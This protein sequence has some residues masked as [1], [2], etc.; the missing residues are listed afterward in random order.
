MRELEAGGDLV[1]TSGRSAN[2]SPAELSLCLLIIVHAC[3]DGPV[4][5]IL[6]AVLGCVLF[7]LIELLVCILSWLET[8]DKHTTK[9]QD[10]FS[11]L[12]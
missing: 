4:V 9:T 2:D 11:P 6:V 10:S 1:D 12:S 5:D 7:D 8:T 3:E